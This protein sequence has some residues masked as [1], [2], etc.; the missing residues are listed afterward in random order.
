MSTEETLRQLVN[1][2]AGA[3]L[4]TDAQGLLLVANLR[5][6]ALFPA[7][8]EG[9][10]VS[11]VIRNSEF[12]ENFHLILEGG[13][14][15]EV[16]FVLRKPSKRHL[17]ANIIGIDGERGERFVFIHL[18][19]REEEENLARMRMNFIASASHEL[20][21][22]LASL[23]GFIETLQ[24]AAKDDPVAREQFL[25][26]MEAQARR[27]QRLLD[28]LLSLSRIEMEAHTVPEDTVDMNAL[29]E[30]VVET[31]R[32]QAEEHGVLLELVRDAG[33]AVVRGNA[34]QLEQVAQNLIS[35]AITYGGEGGRVRI[36]VRSL[37]AGRKHGPRV[38]FSVRDFGPGI[39]KEH[40]PHL[41][42]RFYRVDKQASRNRGGTGLGLA[43]VKHL[44]Q[45]HRGVLKIR[46]KP[47]EGAKFTVEIPAADE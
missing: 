30:R 28:D 3:A 9:R 32:L 8:M 25:E 2:F 33:N 22:P 6:R 17:G 10:L 18:R 34:D 36:R 5:A 26:I 15:T 35:N 7:L 20:R 38:A 40:I 47:G 1:G 37:P 14:S 21:T 43:I 24:G 12:Q 13:R 39:A 16:A 23:L 42:E 41:T 46:S 27:M 31:M 44:V 4:L 45:A 19:D 29:A 11:G